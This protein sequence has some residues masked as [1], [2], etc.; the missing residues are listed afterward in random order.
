V[1]VP[2]VD[3]A[4][5]GAAPPAPTTT[6]TIATPPPTITVP[7][8]QE[9]ALKRI[10]V[11]RARM[12]AA[13]AAAAYTKAETDLAKTEKQV[14]ALEARIPR[15][16][17]RIDA[18]KKLL[19]ERAAVLYRGGTGGGLTMLEAMSNG[20]ILGSGRVARLADAANENTDAQMKDL[21]HNRD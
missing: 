12:D 4:A 16:Q 11:E 5:A 15:I 19:E 1:A 21:S 17:V 6:T 18:L 2:A 20:D 7:T 3:A 9:I 10:A 8:D 14:K 13:K